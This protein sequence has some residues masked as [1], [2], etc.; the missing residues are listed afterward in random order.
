MPT[1]EIFIG[2]AEI[3]PGFAA[4]FISIG[5]RCE[6]QKDMEGALEAYASAVE[7]EL[8]YAVSVFGR[9]GFIR[10]QSTDWVDAYAMAGG[11]VGLGGGQEDPDS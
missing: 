1:F 2:E 11:E 10:L 4:G 6:E 5:L 9:R 7:A 3:D 8:D